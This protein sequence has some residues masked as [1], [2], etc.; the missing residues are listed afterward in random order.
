M[1]FLVQDD[2]GSVEDANAYITVAFLDAFHADRANSLVGFTSTNKETAIV[3]ATDYLDGRF[4]FIGDKT[5]V[6]QRTAWPRAS[7]V[8]R[9]GNVR[10]GIPFEIKEATCEYAFRALTV[11]LNP[12]PV[13][14]ATGQIVQS[15]SESVGPISE[16]VSYIG[17]G[18]FVMPSYPAADN[19]LRAS[20]LVVSGRDA[21]RA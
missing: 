10:G 16:S 5:T 3:R 15:K 6:Q 2:A 17:G 20:G 18:G 12:D 8:D 9:E 19:R 14:D 4:I 11:P 7:A 21:G 1:P 13:R